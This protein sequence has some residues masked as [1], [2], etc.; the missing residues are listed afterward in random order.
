MYFLTMHQT[1]DPSRIVSL[2]R[3]NRACGQENFSASVNCSC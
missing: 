3:K 2:N 1:Q